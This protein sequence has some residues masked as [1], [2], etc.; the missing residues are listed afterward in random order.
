MRALLKERKKWVS[1]LS[2][3]QNIGPL[4]WWCPC[5]Q[6]PLASKVSFFL[7][8]FFIYNFQIFH[9][10]IVICFIQ[11]GLYK[12]RVGQTQLRVY[13]RV[14]TMHIYTKLF[15]WEPFGQIAFNCEIS[16]TVYLN[17]NFSHSLNLPPSK[18]NNLAQN[19]TW[20]SSLSPYP[21]S[22]TGQMS[23]Y[24][25]VYVWCFL[26]FFSTPHSCWIPMVVFSVCS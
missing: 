16:S 1:L 4:F 19:R 8:L 20:G 13:T 11:K 22:E 5:P 15:S 17:W 3:Y 12:D 24:N 2:Y 9:I 18:C 26:T 14:S 21:P 6:L 23:D 10:S 25:V 7:P